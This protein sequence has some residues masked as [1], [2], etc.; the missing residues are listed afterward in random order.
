MQHWC[1]LMGS[2]IF[3]V[4]YAKLVTDPDENMI[5]IMAFLE[6]DWSEPKLNEPRQNTRRIRTASNWQVRQKIYTTSIDRWKNY[7]RLAKEFMSHWDF[8][9]NRRIMVLIQNSQG[10]GDRA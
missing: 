8:F 3:Q 4:D 1:S 2:R 5:G 6:R 9:K 7:P 10:P